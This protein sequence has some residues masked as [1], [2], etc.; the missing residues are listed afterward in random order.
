VHRGRALIV[1][2]TAAGTLLLGL[3]LAPSAQAIRPR[4]DAVVTEPPLLNWR[5]VDRAVRYNVQLWRDGQKVLSRFP[6]RS[7]LQLDSRWSFGGTTYRFSPG[8]YRWFVWPWLGRRYGRLRVNSSFTFVRPPRNVEPPAVSGVAREGAR[9]TAGRGRWRGTRPLQFTYTWQRCDAAGCV[10]I[11]GASG[12]AVIVGA[13]A[14]DRRIRVVVR[15]TNLARSRTAASGQTEV[16]LPAPPANA[17]RPE[18]RGR[19]QQGRTLLGLTGVWR[20]SRPLTFAFRWLRCDAHGRACGSISGASGQAYAT[21]PADFERRLRLHVTAVNGGG[22][23]A[24]FSV[25]TPV[26]GRVYVGT[27][28]SDIL[29]G[30]RGADVLRGGAGADVLAGGRGHDRIRGGGGNDRLAGGRGADLLLARDGAWDAIDCGRGADRGVADR[31][32]QVSRNCER[33]RRR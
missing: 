6:V 25:A 17:S 29:R 12:P 21:V 7:R 2:G 13:S 9:L 33:V 8:V 4:A 30:S 19:F 32:D 15:A 11:A 24:A 5:S 27:S 28:G 10:T 18:I 1:C 22:E 16:V 14:I 26:L 3:A 31:G 23:T 20:S